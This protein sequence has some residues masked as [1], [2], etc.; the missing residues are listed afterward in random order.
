[1]EIHLQDKF[2]EADLPHSKL[3]LAGAF[4]P[5]SGYAFYCAALATGI[6]VSQQR[7]RAG[8]KPSLTW[9][10]RVRSFFV[11]WG[12][13]VSIHIF[14]YEAG[15]NTLGECLLFVASLFGVN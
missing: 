14:E 11:V 6:G 15:N 2:A 7:A 3:G 9:V 12:F 5:M 4:A 10:G 13:V 1:M 8:V